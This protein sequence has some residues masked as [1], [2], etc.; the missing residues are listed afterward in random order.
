MYRYPVANPRHY[1]VHVGQA[2]VQN[3]QPP[4]TQAQQAA[5]DDATATD[6]AKA[7]RQITPT[8]LLIGIATGFAFAVGSA[9]AGALI[10]QYV[11]PK[12]PRR[13]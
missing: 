7:V 4:Q 6:L 2:L 1:A 11:F 13:S 10:D 12:H 8:F 5:V 3:A 9:I